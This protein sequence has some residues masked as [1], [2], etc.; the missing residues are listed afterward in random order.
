MT[1]IAILGATGHIGTALAHHYINRRDVTLDLYSRS[2]S[3][4][5]ARFADLNEQ[6]GVFHRPLASLDLF[7]CDIVINALGAGDPRR[8]KEMGSEILT[9]TLHWEEMISRALQS[10]PAALYVFLSSGAVYGRLSGG[11]ARIDAVASF[12]VNRRPCEDAYRLAKFMAEV[13]H[14]ACPA[15]RIV[16]IRI[17]GF[18]SPFL[19]LAGKYFL[20]ELFLALLDGQVFRTAPDDMTR[21]YVGAEEIAQLIDHCALQREIN[22]AVDIYTSRP[23]G[24]F[25]LLAQLEKLGLRWTVDPSIPSHPDRITYASAYDVANRV[26]YRPHRTASEVVEDVARQLIGRR[27]HPADVSARPA[28]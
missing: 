17:F 1:R 15:R 10:N 2:P 12:H 20:S 21:D 11:P 24:K 25:E 9:L 4:T 13:Q 22:M 5:L 23:A 14:R 18:A 6:A 28:P 16:D 3:T 8:V 7:E 27:V 19:D 26:G